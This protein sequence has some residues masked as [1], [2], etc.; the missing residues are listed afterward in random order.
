[1]S[2]GATRSSQLLAAAAPARESVALPP[3]PPSPGPALRDYAL[4]ELQ[5]ADD[6]LG[7]AGDELHEG[8]HRARK[9]L[10]RAR[11]AL[12]LGD[13]ILGPGVGLLDRELKR[14]NTGLSSLRDAHAL[15]E[16]LDRL[17][18]RTRKAAT[19]QLLA[20]A[21]RRGRRRPRGPYAESEISL[22]PGAGPAPRPD[23]AAPHRRARARLGS[24]DPLG[25]AHGPGRQ[26]RTHAAG[27]RAGRAQG[28][29]RRLAPLAPA[30][31]PCLPA[32]SRDGGRQLE[33]RTGWPPSTSA[34]PSVSARP[35]T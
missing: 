5:A 10:R 19:Q 26:R 18:K 27:A 29:R 24:P 21:R 25:P 11:S 20:Q 28:Q 9:G 34:P 1:M 6:A 31:T 12:A 2:K 22:R 16:T 8:V 17:L 30:R 33:D 14:I 32:T 4:A 13:G 3:P 7:H 15:V 23:Q 35:R